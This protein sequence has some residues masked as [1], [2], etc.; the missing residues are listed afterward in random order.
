MYELD[1]KVKLSTGSQQDRETSGFHVLLR[2]THEGREAPH[3]S[4]N[5]PVFTTE[6]SFS[7]Y[8][9]PMY[10]ALLYLLS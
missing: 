2:M 9:L 3:I 4:H 10:D 5:G 6:T 7:V 1:G 8:T